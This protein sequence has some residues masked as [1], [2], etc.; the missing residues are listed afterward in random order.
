[1]NCCHESS[2]LCLKK[3]WSHFELFFNYTLSFVA[4]L[5]KKEIKWQWL[6]QVLFRQYCYCNLILGGSFVFFS[7]IL[8]K[9]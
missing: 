9:S 6:S 8:G 7:L 5:T 2:I 4:L 3:I 1:M